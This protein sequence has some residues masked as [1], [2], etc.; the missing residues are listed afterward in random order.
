MHLDWLV[1]R[2]GTAVGS[3]RVS[4]ERRGRT[5]ARSR[6][7][8]VDL[9]A[10]VRGKLSLLPGAAALLLSLGAQAT[11]LDDY[12]RGTG[13]HLSSAAV[14]VE[15]NEYYTRDYD[16]TK[17]ADSL[18]L[19]IDLHE[20]GLSADASVI[21]HGSTAGGQLVWTFDHAFSP[22]LDL[23]GGN[24]VMRVA[25]ELV[26]NARPSPGTASLACA[27][28]PCD[29]S[30][31]LQKAAGSHVDVWGHS[32]D[33]LFGWI[34]Q[35]WFR[36]VT[37]LEFLAHAGLPRPPLAD[38]AIEAP[39]TGRFCTSDRDRAYAA[40]VRLSSVAPVG[41]VLVNVGSD[42]ATALRTRRVWV[43][44]GEDS[45]SFTLVFPGAFSGDVHVGAAS[46]GVSMSRSLRLDPCFPTIDE[47]VVVDDWFNERY[48]TCEACM[49]A[50]RLND[51]GT[52]LVRSKGDWLAARRRGGRRQ[53]R[54]RLR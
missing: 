36:S 13:V 25:G 29:Y 17:A 30:I 49:E 16:G 18:D 33:T 45:A 38:L 48:G 7:G 43:A 41:G 54:R 20:F 23:G 15:D 2:R 21:L 12:R 40:R 53:G 26:A 1:G 52:A 51:R 32:Q 24:F 37:D 5:K 42:H 11:P 10:A 6:L 34:S 28:A 19:A 47:R 35:D 8:R 22:P 50:L 27:G 4:L 31:V 3:T 39:A 14:R 46:G 44:A 9:P